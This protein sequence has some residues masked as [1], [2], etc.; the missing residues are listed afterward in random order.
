MRTFSKVVPASGRLERLG[1]EVCLCSKIYGK[2]VSS[3]KRMEFGSDTSQ[4]LHY[5]SMALCIFAIILMNNVRY[6]FQMGETSRRS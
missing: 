5:M 4:P 3:M 6:C 2:A 1:R